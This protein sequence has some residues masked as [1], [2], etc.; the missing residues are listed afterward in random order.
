MSGAM[1]TMR[2]P[3]P[4]NGG[5]RLIQRRRWAGLLVP[6][7]SLRRT[8]PLMWL[9]CFAACGSWLRRNG[10]A[11]A[12]DGFEDCV[13]TAGQQRRAGG[14]AEFFGI[15][16]VA[17]I[18]QEFRAVGVGDDGLEMQLAVPHFCEGADGNLAASAEAIE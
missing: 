18:A 8:L 12:V 11:T 7:R 9:S 13:S 3:I 5:Q 4:R 1:L 17:G 14:V 10:Q 2:M 15:V 16:A 6:P